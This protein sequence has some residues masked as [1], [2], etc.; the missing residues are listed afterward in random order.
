MLEHIH[1]STLPQQCLNLLLVTVT[2]VYCIKIFMGGVEWQGKILL[3]GYIYT[4]KLLYLYS[5]FRVFTATVV[6][7]PETS[8]NQSPLYTNPK[9]P[10]MYTNHNMVRI[11]LLICINRFV[12]T[13]SNNVPQPQISCNDYWLFT[14]ISE[15]VLLHISHTETNSSC[16]LN[17]SIKYLIFMCH[18][19]LTSIG[20]S[21]FK[22]KLLMLPST[23]YDRLKIFNCMDI[24]WMIALLII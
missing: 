14:K 5:P 3:L 4:T 23:F 2:K 13:L 12:F 21:L 7:L 17:T 19:L 22:Q 18:F 10:I 24:N 15:H 20:Y 1:L 16:V 8:I 9:W 6:G 11:G